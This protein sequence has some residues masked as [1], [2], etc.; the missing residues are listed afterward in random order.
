MHPTVAQIIDSK[1]GRVVMNGLIKVAKSGGYKNIEK[2]TEAISK[3]VK[4]AGSNPGA[5]TRRAVAGTVINPSLTTAVV[6]D[7]G[8][9]FVAPAYAGS[10]FGLK[11]AAMMAPATMTKSSPTVQKF[12]RNMMRNDGK[13]TASKIGKNIEYQVNRATLGAS[14]A[15]SIMTGYF[16]KHDD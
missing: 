10:P 12:G 13:T 4:M 14:K 16:S 2:N 5:A 3:T 11:H 7:T 1:P 15:G 9:T 8:I 6:A